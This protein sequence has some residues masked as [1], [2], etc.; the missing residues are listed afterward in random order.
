MHTFIKSLV[1][2][3]LTAAILPGC[4]EQKENIKE[5]RFVVTDSLINR[6]LID[7]IGQ[8]NSL[9]SRNFSARIIADEEKMANIF[10]MVSGIVKNVPIK[11][12][13]KVNKGQLLATMESAEMAGFDKEAISASAEL[14]NAERNAQL[15]ED[16]YKDGLA[17]ERELDEARNNL[18]VAQAEHKRSLA[19]L[20]LNGGNKNGTYTIKSPI[21]GF[22]I[23]K[24]VNSNMQVRPDNDQSIF[25]IADLSKVWALINI[26][27]SD[28]SRI[29]EGNEVD[30]Y[31]LSYPEKTFKGKID[32]IYNILDAESKV[33]N[34]RVTIDNP[35]FMLKP[36]MMATVQIAVKSR[37]NL[38]V[39]NSNSVI[40]DNNKNYVL[41]L[42]QEN[43][44]KIQ[45]V[46][47]A[48]KAENKS[49]LSKGIRQGD[50]VIGSK[51]V[52]LYESLK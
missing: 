16:L 4:S 43:K 3:S 27:E 50:R 6:L 38:P 25:K 17:S 21:A 34:A 23:E 37:I 52:F 26:Y 1:L 15:T 41:L 48:Y 45:E 24:N 18:K 8:A 22:V 51:Q 7:T 46:E 12:G 32:K 19:I 40:F 29:E 44:I 14:R 47:V 35:G 33:M 30:I 39:I 36:G 13:D 2:A 10:P 31:V 28:I 49:Y 5:E 11:L 42:D 20:Q 9:S